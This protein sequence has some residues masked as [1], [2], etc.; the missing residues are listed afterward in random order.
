[1]A[2]KATT[3]PTLGDVAKRLDPEGNI[4]AIIELLNEQNEILMDATWVEANGPTSHR[5]TVR[6]GLPS[7][8][9]RKLNYGVQPSKSR[10]VQVT[11]GIGMLEARA[12]VDKDLADLNGNTDDFRLSEDRAFLEA[13]NI[14]LA[15][16]LFYGDSTTA[17]EEFMGL[18]PRFND[19]TAENG[20]NI[21][22]GGGSGSDNTSIWLVVWSPNTCHMIYPKG[23]EGG[24]MHKD[25]GEVTLFDDQ[26]PAGRYQGYE[27]LYQWKA[28]LCLRDWRHVVRIANIDVSDLTK[29]AAT[30]ADIV[31]LMI[32]ALER[33]KSLSI[34]RPAFYCNRTISSFLRRQ[35]N[36]STNVRMTPDQ[37]SGKHV[38][39]F[40]M[41]PVRRCDALLETEATVS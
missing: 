25:L 14:E 3:N 9:W 30:G 36:N 21:L 8:T 35:I 23:G 17:P 4:A 18:E 27:S 13:M 37:V 24:L 41:V 31:D 6:S 2:T 28:G 16:T 40:D 5:T 19:T 38:L 15:E 32:Q 10:T 11:D 29:D 33:V 39:T 20:D 26:T 22:L 12:T 1:M 34:G 7:V